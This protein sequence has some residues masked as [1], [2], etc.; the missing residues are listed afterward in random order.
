MPTLP[1]SCDHSPRVSGNLRYSNL[2][3]NAVQNVTMGQGGVGEM[4]IQDRDPALIVKAPLLE[5]EK[6]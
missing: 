3:R 1:N 2:L 4:R 6:K 5:R